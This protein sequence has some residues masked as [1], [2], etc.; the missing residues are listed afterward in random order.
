MNSQI[1]NISRKIAWRILP[2]AL[3]GYFL[4]YIDKI[5]VGFAA[6]TMRTDLGMSATAFGFATGLFFWTYA[7]LEVPSNM[8]MSR[9]GP[10][11]WLSRIM[12]TW[13]IISACTFLV[14]DSIDYSIVRIL[15]G[16]AEAGFFPGILF[17][18]TFWFPQKFMAR[19]CGLFTLAL[20]FSPMIGAPI[21]TAILG[22]DGMLGLKGW[23]IMFLVEAIPAI[24]FGILLLFILP[25]NPDSINW[26][27]TQEKIELKQ[28][29]SE[30]KLPDNKNSG[31]WRTISD[32]QVL[33]L[34]SVMLCYTIGSIGMVIFLPQ[35]IQSLGKQTIMTTGWLTSLPYIVG[36]ISLV[37]FGWSSDKFN[38]RRWHVSFGLTA[39]TVGFILAA[40]TMGSYWALIGI[41]IAAA[42]MYGKMGALWALSSGILTQSR[43]AVGFAFINSV[44]NLGGFIGPFLIGWARDYTGT[45]AGSFAVLAFFSLIGAIISITCLRR[46]KEL[47]KI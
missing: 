39:T 12:I 35:I 24:I 40:S 15:L 27:N 26:L 7:F 36:A 18:F 3:I 45:Y 29:L 22:L 8:I 6:L 16:A 5:N 14:K 2:L 34:C 25:N 32:S 9:V 1:D 20:V 42:G 19:A 44:G 30:N 10:R 33:L 41:S 37:V 28:S 23:Q 31:W 4:A 11:I 21:S 46:E 43:S 17:Y 47:I 38:E 13:G